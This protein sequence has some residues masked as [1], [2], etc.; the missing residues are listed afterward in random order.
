[1]DCCFVLSKLHA[2]VCAHNLFVEAFAR[3]TFANFENGGL[4]RE[5]L[6]REII[7]KITFRECLSREI[8]SKMTFRESL[9]CEILS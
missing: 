9:S 6:S 7:S 4:V 3:E 5:S 8:F 2:I 1:M